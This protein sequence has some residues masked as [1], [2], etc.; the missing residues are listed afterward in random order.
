MVYGFGAWGSG[1][2]VYGVVF[3]HWGLGTGGPAKPKTGTGRS[4]AAGWWG[5]GVVKGGGS[6]GLR[7]R[8]FRVLGGYSMQGL[9]FMVSGLLG[10]GV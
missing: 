7:G 3:V 5:G 9:G 2:M 6:L 1:S 4:H 10:P 8:A